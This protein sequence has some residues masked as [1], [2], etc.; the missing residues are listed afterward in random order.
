MHIAGRFDPGRK[1]VLYGAGQLASMALALWPDDTPRPLLLIDEFSR[2]RALDG[3]PVR[4]LAQVDAGLLRESQVVLSAFKLDPFAVAEKLAERGASIGLTVY[5]LFES[6]IA[7]RFSNG[8]RLDDADPEVRR[9]LAAGRVLLADELSRAVWDDVVDWRCRRR[10]RPDAL[11]RIEPE[12][13]KYINALTRELIAAA[14][15]L[16]DGGAYDGGFLSSAAA[17][18]APQATLVA[19][20]P[21][22]VSF[23]RSCSALAALA[24]RRVEPRPLALGGAC[25]QR[26]FYSTGGLSARLVEPAHANTAVAC[27]TID[28]QPWPAPA[29]MPAALGRPVLKLH[30]E[31][32]ELEAIEGAARFIG[33]RRPLV[34]V[35]CSHNADG[36]LRIPQRLAQLGLQDIWLRTHALFGE[37]VTLYAL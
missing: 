8:W 17:L 9:A 25:G 1:T 23:E 20:E 31:G 6:T 14:P 28:A 21:D 18:V 3:I 12:S 26:P 37:G 15:L 32:A 22:P 24:G 35:N 27:T 5:D 10:L 2:E 29:E 4:R 33:E 13:D 30:I 34:M 7:P 16:V 19:F 11:R 36:L